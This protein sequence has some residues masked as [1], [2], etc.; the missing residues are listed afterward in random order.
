MLGNEA[1]QAF[2]MSLTL[3]FLAAILG[4]AAAA[5]AA[6]FGAGGRFCG[7]R[8]TGSRFFLGCFGRRYHGLCLLCRRG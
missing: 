6:G 2:S 7:G 8:G 1:S 4:A 5:G 3:M